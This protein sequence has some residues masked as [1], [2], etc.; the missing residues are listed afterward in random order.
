MVRLQYDDREVPDREHR[1][2]PWP[3]VAL[4]AKLNLS[5]GTEGSDPEAENGNLRSGPHLL[6]GAAT[7]WAQVRAGPQAQRSPR[8]TP[9]LLPLWQR[10]QQPATEA[11]AWLR[12]AA[13]TI[14]IRVI[15]CRRTGPTLQELML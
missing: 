1:A 6:V 3:R 11:L 14:E 2:W 4:S 5:Q 10:S 12:T 7:A 9:E 13:S 15:S 8:L